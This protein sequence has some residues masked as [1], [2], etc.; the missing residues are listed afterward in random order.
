MPQLRIIH[1]GLCI[2][3]ALIA[4]LLGAL[5]PF[6]PGAG[7]DLP[8]LVQWT[9][10]GF[11]G[12]TILTGAYLRTTIAVMEGIDEEAWVNANQAKCVMV[13]GVVDGGVCLCA[14]AL[15]LGATP[16]VAG[17]LAAGGLGFLASQS[18]GTLAGH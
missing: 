2:S 7:V 8:T 11:A 17:G 15:F 10:L 4:L 3:A 18:P 12:M 14:I 6:G 16:W 1:L 9:L 5:R 13:W